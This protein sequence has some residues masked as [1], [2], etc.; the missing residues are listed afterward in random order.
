MPQVALA[1][2]QSGIFSFLIRESLYSSEKEILDLDF[3]YFRYRLKQLKE[4]DDKVERETEKMKSEAK[5]R[6]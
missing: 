6:K 3:H 2:I 1:D 5:S 4:F